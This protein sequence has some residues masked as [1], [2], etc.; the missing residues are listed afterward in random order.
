MS[1]ISSDKI[2]KFLDWVLD[3]GVIFTGIELQ[4]CGP[5]IGFGFFA[6]KQLRCHE[7]VIELPK[8]LMIT[9]GL[10]AEIPEYAA[11]LKRYICDAKITIFLVI[12]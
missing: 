11:F 9:A 5:N 8:K 1:S 2:Q 12:D 6:T 7:N 10:V 4:Y 3:E